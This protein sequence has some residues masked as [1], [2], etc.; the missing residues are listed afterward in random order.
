MPVA[1]RW[2]ALDARFFQLGCKVDSGFDCF[3][4][5]LSASERTGTQETA[6]A[7]KRNG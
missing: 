4:I 7:H 3:M 5:A 6:K 2:A 1:V